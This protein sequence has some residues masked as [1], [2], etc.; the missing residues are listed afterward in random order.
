LKPWEPIKKPFRFVS[1]VPYV[2]LVALLIWLWTMIP[3]PTQPEADVNLELMTP[4]VV[5]DAGHGGHDNGAVRNGLVEKILALDTA[6]RLERLLK[7]RGFTVVMTRTDDRFLELFDRAQIANQ[8]PRALFVSVHY[9]DNATESGEGVETLYATEKVAGS[10]GGLFA[11]KVEAPPADKGAGFA[12]AI[13]RQVISRLGVLDRGTKARQLAVLR[14]TRC[15]AI[16]VEGGFINNPADAK[17]VRD[18]AYRERLASAVAEGI[19]AFH[20]KRILD[21]N[22]QPLAKA[23]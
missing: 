18:P 13:H 15:P 23:Q 2:A 1:L 6:Q 20:K 4:V 5:V 16:L 8:F 9:N 22:A 3:H 11:K 17:R 14:H 12:E 7:K 19:E 10:N 21:A